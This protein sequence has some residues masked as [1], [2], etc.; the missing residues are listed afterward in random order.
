M[1]ESVKRKPFTMYDITYIESLADQFCI[2]NYGTPTGN[3]SVRDAFIA[4]F[5]LM[6]TE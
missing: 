1:K 2:K 5:Y 4:G 6:I 3:K